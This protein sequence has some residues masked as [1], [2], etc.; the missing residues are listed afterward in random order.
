VVEIIIAFASLQHR[1]S[2]CHH[3]PSLFGLGSFGL[4][5]WRKQASVALESVNLASYFE[6][7]VAISKELPI[8][9]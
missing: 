7:L 6:D 3:G 1:N 9:S 2:C 4:G 5:E 8:V